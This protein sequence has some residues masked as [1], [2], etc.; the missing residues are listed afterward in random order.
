MAKKKRKALKWMRL[1]NAAKIY[2]A[3]KSNSWSNVFRESITLSENVDTEV[4]RSAL[5]VTVRRFPS[6]AARLRKGL[7]W[8]YLQE[9]DI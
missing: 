8:Y 5:K 6:I 9:I 1:D 7:F 4:L 2:P 3:A